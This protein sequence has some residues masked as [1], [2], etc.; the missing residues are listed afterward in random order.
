MFEKKKN[1]IM[2]IWWKDFEDL[3]VGLVAF[4]ISVLIL[5]VIWEMC[6]CQWRD[7]AKEEGSPGSSSEIGIQ[8]MLKWPT[9]YPVHLALQK[10]I[11]C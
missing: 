9:N 10:S 3:G 6:I 11:L 5:E 4:S 2:L 7:S 8:R 1:N